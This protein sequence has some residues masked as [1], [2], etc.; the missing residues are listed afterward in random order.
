MLD[1]SVPC[2]LGD[3]LSGFGSR[4]ICAAIPSDS[5]LQRADGS[6]RIVLSGSEKGTSLMEVFQQS[7]IRVMFPGIGGVGGKGGVLFYTGGGVG[8]GGPAKRS[9][10]RR[11]QV[12]IS[13]ANT[14]CVKSGP[15]ID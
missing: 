4:E 9:L 6:C 12:S 2:D 15:P 3:D 10:D 14:A 5:D 13:L 1:P 8:C 7:P 11:G